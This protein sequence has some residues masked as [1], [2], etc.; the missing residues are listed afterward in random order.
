MTNK[1]KKKR[2][3]LNEPEQHNPRPVC[4]KCGHKTRGEKGMKQHMKD[5][6]D[7]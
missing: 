3:R 7:E 4:P 5:K 2:V 6:H 1:R